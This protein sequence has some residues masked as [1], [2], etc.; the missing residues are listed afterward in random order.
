MSVIIHANGLC[1]SRHVGDGT[2]VR[3]FAQIM[4]GARVGTEC[5]IWSHVLI[6]S[7]VEIG[8]RVTVKSG[9]QIWEG[10]RIGNGVT[11]GPNA[12]FCSVTSH[13][14]L[15]PRRKATGT[16]IEDGASVGANATVL[17]G[18][19]IGKNAIVEAGAVVTID[20]PANAI[21][22]ENPAR[23]RGYADKARCITPQALDEDRFAPGEDKLECSVRGVALYRLTV[24]S[25]LRGSLCAGEF[26]EQI[27]FQPRRFFAICDVPDLNVRGEHAHKRCHQFLIALRGSCSLVVDDGM[28]REEFELSG[29]EVGLYMPPMI[30]GVQYKHTED[31]VLL[32][33]A[34]DAYDPE[35]YIRDYEEFL[36]RASN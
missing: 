22:A 6:E 35:D 10:M 33:L 25:D 17:A 24:V 8:D 34:S 13:G 18:V 26:P 19:T 27:P 12:T 9:V 16:T 29:P 32:V 4:E 7:G 3:A 31:A 28:R 36:E 5:S 2:R 1:E 21:V 11:I 30:W 15:G 14:D 20:V 23:I